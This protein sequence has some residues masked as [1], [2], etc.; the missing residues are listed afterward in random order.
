MENLEKIKVLHVHG[1]LVAGGGQVLSREWLS[2][3]DKT[4]FES[5]V[6]VLNNPL[7]LKKSFEE[8]AIPVDVI[9]GNRIQQILK[10]VKYIRVHKFDVVHTQSE[11]DRKV[12]HWAALLTR[13]PVVAS[14]H[15]QWV[16]FSPVV[17]MSIFR[18]IKFQISLLLRK[19][20][21]K[22][23]V[24]FVATSNAVKSEY[25]KYTS[26]DIYVVEPGIQVIDEHLNREDRES[27][28][29]RL[30][31]KP[32]QKLI[33]NAS[34]LDSLKNLD[35]FVL[36]VAKLKREH[37]V[38]GHIYGEGERAL[39]INKLIYDLDCGDFIKVLSP[40]IDLGE[41]L[42]ASDIYLAPSL[43]ES[44]GM[45]IVEAMSRAVPVVAYDL[46]AYEKFSNSISLIKKGD[47]DSLVLETSKLLLDN[48]EYNHLAGKGI[49][50]SKKYDIKIGIRQVQEI[51]ESIV[52]RI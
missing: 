30:G 39:L 27:I 44:F 17:Q 22:S 6:V 42:N 16:Y 50:T 52:G 34:R 3:L 5:R 33:V 47:V 41:I 38:V 51:Y 8:K 4:G 28:R 9:S 36:A 19:I 2:G 26:K 13:K 37:D 49:E 48:S 29:E 11:P 35:D 21:E 32:N 23:V 15:S 46:P 14:L 31:I 12:G 20:S 45:S 7:T 18:K 25:S 10:L 43:S 40:V 1:D 24:S